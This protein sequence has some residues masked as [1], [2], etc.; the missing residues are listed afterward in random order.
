[1]QYENKS[2]IEN[3]QVFFNNEIDRLLHIIDKDD[4]HKEVAKRKQLKSAGVTRGVRY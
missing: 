2:N 4:N 1:V 3:L